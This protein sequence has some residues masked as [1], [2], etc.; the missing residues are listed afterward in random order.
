MATLVKPPN[1][2]QGPPSYPSHSPVTA[3]RAALGAVAV[4]GAWMALLAGVHLAHP[5][6][7]AD[8]L[9]Q[10]GIEGGEQIEAIVSEHGTDV[11]VDEGDRACRWMGDQEKAWLNHGPWFS[12]EGVIARYLEQT[13]PVVVTG[14]WGPPATWDSNRAVVAS[15]AFDQLCGGTW[16]THRPHGPEPTRGGGGGGGD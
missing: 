13:R 2:R 5:R 6:S 7:E 8:F 12:R 9:A 4:V 10:A 3:K 16:W 15:A 11:L 14:V 1:L